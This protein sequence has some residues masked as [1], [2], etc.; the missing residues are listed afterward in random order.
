MFGG[1]EEWVEERKLLELGS[2]TGTPAGA[3]G[4]AP[5]EGEGEGRVKNLKILRSPESGTQPPDEELYL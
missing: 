2:K 4:E 3:G 5:S 1:E